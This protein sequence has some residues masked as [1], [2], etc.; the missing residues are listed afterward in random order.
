MAASL[1]LIPSIHSA[2]SAVANDL[3]ERRQ[4]DPLEQAAILIPN[5]DAERHA[6][7]FLGNQAGTRFLLFSSLSRALLREHGVLARGIDN[8]TIRRLVSRLLA[9][10]QDKGKITSFSSV[11]SK[12]GFVKELTRWL[13]EMKEQGISPADY[14]RYASNDTSADV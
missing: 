9:E 1:Y 14:A 2:L 10:G 11:A 5:S 13:L 7:Q 8:L 3:R 4:N 12:P 6:R